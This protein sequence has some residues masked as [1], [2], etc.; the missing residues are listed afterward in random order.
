VTDSQ[1]KR[2]P[3]ILRVIARLNV[4]GPARHVVLLDRG[5][6]AR[7]YDTLLVHGSVGE[8][9]SSFEHLAYE[10]G[11]DVVKIAELGRRISAIS[12]LRAFVRL[13]G[14]MFRRQPDVV[15]T[16]TAKA[17]TVGRLAALVYNAT[18]GR[19]RRALVIHTFHGHVLSGYFNPVV[20]SMVR[21]VERCLARA[22]T[23][24]IVTLSPAQRE[25]IANRFH[26][27]PLSRIVVV[28]LGLDLAALLK[29]SNGSRNL[30]RHL[31]IPSDAIV[32]GYV[33]RFV[34]IKDLGTLV[35]AFAAAARTC[36]QLFLVLAGDG[37]Q[38]AS[39]ERQ[40][41]ELGMGQ[42]VRFVGWCEDL[43]PLYATFDICVIA[44]LNEGTPVA[45]IE[46][47]AAAK[48]VIAT[49]VG[50]VPDVVED[51]RTGVLVPAGD[52]ER[53]AISIADLACDPEK[54]WRFG[55]A[56]REVVAERF[57]CDRLV[58]D[59]D[60]LYSEALGEKRFAGR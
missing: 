3:R 27:A 7:G 2:S 58:G 19:R 11:I 29:V 48:P 40:S 1:P 13:V 25:E 49:S 39:L 24:R 38:R 32:V 46:A 45:V 4:G 9:E 21:W 34:P 14:L 16:H 53:L 47:M 30:R 6:K 31:D 59:I 26:I 12:D 41:R 36:P 23:D 60:V 43:P 56:G 54:R 15:H 28:P 10:G 37:P 50:G 52:A 55:A 5:L 44:S 18:R 33:G 57:S 8:G 22:T 51:G 17:G 20:N 42:R 35:G